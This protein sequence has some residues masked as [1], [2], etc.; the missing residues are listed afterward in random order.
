MSTSNEIP[1]QTGRPTKTYESRDIMQTEIIVV[2]GA[3]GLT[4]D[5]L[6]Q[7]PPAVVPALTLANVPAEFRGSVVESHS[8]WPRTWEA[9]DADQT[10]QAVGYIEQLVQRSGFAE[11]FEISVSGCS[12][13]VN[14][15]L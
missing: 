1:G 11:R 3:D 4:P 13:T 14:R 10:A 12:I 5:M 8:G 15:Q 7:Y 9:G 6:R 2:D